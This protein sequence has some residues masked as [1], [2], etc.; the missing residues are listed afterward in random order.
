MARCLLHWSCSEWRPTATFSGLTLPEMP[1]YPRYLMT[2]QR[3]LKRPP[4]TTAR[5][6]PWWITTTT[7]TIIVWAKYELGFQ[8]TKDT[9]IVSIHAL[10]AFRNFIF[11]PN[12]WLNTFSRN[13]IL[14]SN[15]ICHYKFLVWKKIKIVE[16]ILSGFLSKGGGSMMTRVQFFS[17][18]NILY[19]SLYM[20]PNVFHI[21]FFTKSIFIRVTYTTFKNMYLTYLYYT[22]L[23]ICV[24]FLS[25][26]AFEILQK[27]EEKKLLK[28][29]AST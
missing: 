1:S 13:L 25:H 15:L 6:K 9:V 20:T 8:L 10:L 18:R 12:F 29:N 14:S 16:R 7:T 5:T 17:Y 24:L 28:I 23:C 11:L 26:Q 4:T 2:A 21:L 3:P 27:D 19:L 22:F